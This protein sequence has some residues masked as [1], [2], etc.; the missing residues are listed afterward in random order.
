MTPSLDSQI[1]ILIEDINQANTES[2][3][4]IILQ[5]L[6]KLDLDD[7]LEWC[8]HY[9]GCLTCILLSIL[10]MPSARKDEYIDDAERFLKRLYLVKPND[11]EVLVLNAFWYQAKIMIAVLIRG[12]LYMQ[13]IDKLLEKAMA[14][15]PDNPRIY[16][17]MAQSVYNKPRFIGGGKKKA[18]PILLE[19]KAKFESFEADSEIAPDWGYDH[20]LRMIAKITEDL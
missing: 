10:E 8:V 3:Y 17:L 6:H 9:Y 1:K 20:T 4:L 15:N 2:E 13:E 16:F 7:S 18:Y 11:S 14:I 5:K 19:A 12:P